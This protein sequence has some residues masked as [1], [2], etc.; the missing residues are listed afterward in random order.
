VW[1]SK[2]TVLQKEFFK[3]LTTE[4]VRMW[5]SKTGNDD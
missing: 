4:A 2:V 5:L 1:I 3:P